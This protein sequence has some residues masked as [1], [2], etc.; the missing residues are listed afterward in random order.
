MI[1]SD[2]FRPNVGIILSNSDGH[3]FW[4]KRIGQRAWQFPQGGIRSYESAEDAL[5]RE[6]WEETGLES[7]HVEIA[8]R[9]RGWLRYRLP[10]RMIRRHSHPICI[11]QKQV[12]FLLHLRGDDAC[13]NLCSTHKPEFDGWR[14][15][16]YWLP[17]SEVVSFKRRVYERALRELEPLLFGDERARSVEMPHRVS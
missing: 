16:D 9:T 2:G 11:G 15:V 14:W 13:F 4:G 6:L 5:Y 3:V 8:G 7:C 12:W 10:R 1:D 17:A